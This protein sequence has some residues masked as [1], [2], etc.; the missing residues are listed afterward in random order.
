MA[1]KERSSLFIVLFIIALLVFVFVFP[2]ILISQLG[3]GNPWTSYLYQYGFGAIVFLIGINLIIRSGA[4]QLSR[5]RDKYW[6]KWIIFGFFVFAITHLVWILLA[7]HIP[8]K[9]VL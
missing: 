3:S 7:I 1:K 9:G 5:V 6:F 8:V 4:C 2:R